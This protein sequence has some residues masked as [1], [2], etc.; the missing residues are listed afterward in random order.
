MPPKIALLTTDGVPLDDHPLPD[1]SEGMPMLTAGYDRGKDLVL[2]ASGFFFADGKM[3]TVA[4]ILAVDDKGIIRERYYEDRH[5]VDL[6]A[7][8]FKERDMMGVSGTWAVTGDGKVVIAQDWDDYRLHVY[9]PEG[10]LV[11][12]VERPFEPHERSAKEREHA[13]KRFSMNI[14]GTQM[15][16]VVS[17]TDRVIDGVYPRKDGGF[18]I[19]IREKMPDDPP[20]LFARLDQFD[21]Q[22]KWIEQWRLFG[23]V[24][25]NRD[26]L[27]LGDTRVYVAHNLGDTVVEDEDE[28]AEGDM[29]PLHLVCY[30]LES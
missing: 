28:T 23:D 22:G 12:I 7:E 16:V 9:S 20:D 11:R 30:R 3:G 8:Q 25:L 1:P 15:K 6:A 10:K 5:P 14:N 21:A 24:N 19:L 17:D 27:F 13:S 29:Q 4:Q 2:A 26:R 18:Q